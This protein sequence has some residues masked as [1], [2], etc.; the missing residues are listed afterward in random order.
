VSSTGSTIP[1]KEALTVS[2]IVPHYDD[3]AALNRCLQSLEAQT[4]PKNKVEIIVAD[5]DTP[6]GLGEMP[7]EFPDIKFL[8]VRERGAAP[9]RNAAMAVAQNDILAFQQ[10]VANMGSADY[11]GG[12]IEVTFVDEEKPSAIEAFE[13]VFGFR[14]AWYLKRKR[15][16]ATANL[17]VHREVANTIGP[18]R[19]HVAEDLDWGRR[20]DALGFRLAFNAKPI[21]NHPARQDWNALTSKWDRLIK[22]RWC[23]FEAGSPYRDVK[24]TCLAIAT[25]L[26]FAPHAWTVM[27]SRKLN[28]LKDK[29]AAIGILIRIRYWRARRMVALLAT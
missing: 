21:V 22:E 26:S 23:G 9:A 5:N 24:W 12:H 14:Q 18:F 20:A 29:I 13:K 16:S 11:V 10:G 19:N 8:I 2:V 6:G 25:A 27:S 1:P 15:F 4:Y 17:F 7:K 3:V 28:R